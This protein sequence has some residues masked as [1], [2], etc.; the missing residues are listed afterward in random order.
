MTS[1]SKIV[2]KPSSLE[3]STRPEDRGFTMQT[4]AGE[5]PV[6]DVQA[7]KD[8]TECSHDPSN[9]RDDEAI[10]YVTGIRFWLIIA[11]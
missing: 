10:V 4:L 2:D 11:S 1:V 8:E 6:A 5:K 7:A 3:N 9:S